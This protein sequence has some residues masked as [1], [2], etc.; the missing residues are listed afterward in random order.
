MCVVTFTSTHNSLTHN[1]NTLRRSLH[2]NV[3][4]RA[5]KTQACCPRRVFLH[6]VHPPPHVDPSTPIVLRRGRTMDDDDVRS[7]IQ[8]FQYIL[9]WSHQPGHRCDCVHC[10]CGVLRFARRDRL[11]NRV[12][13]CA[14]SLMNVERREACLVMMLRTSSQL[15][16]VP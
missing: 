13:S 15:T 2:C 1:Y 10:V 3:F 5:C 16:V 7:A 4:A 14:S 6:I 11:T 12:N 9:F 8:E